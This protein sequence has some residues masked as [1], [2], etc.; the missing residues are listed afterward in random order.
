MLGRVDRAHVH[1]GIETGTDLKPLDPLLD[2]RAEPVGGVADPD[3]Q[4]LGH[5]ALPRRAVPGRHRRVGRE[6]HVG[7]GQDE[8]RILG[9]GVAPT[10]LPGQCRSRRRS[11]QRGRADELNGVDLGVDEQRGD[12]LT[13]AVDDVED[14]VGQAGL[15][16]QLGLE[17]GGTRGVAGG[18]PDE[19]VAAAS[20]MG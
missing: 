10:R 19:G 17:L 11:G 15:L 18:L 4:G 2:E 8:H 14:A 6:L 1:T 9:R 12:R 13:A 7:V 3:H 5:A 16:P 20:A